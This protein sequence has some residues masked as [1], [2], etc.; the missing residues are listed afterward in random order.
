MNRSPIDHDSSNRIRRTIRKI[1]GK[2]SVG[3]RIVLCA[4]YSMCFYFSVLR[5]STTSLPALFLAGKL[6]IVYQRQELEHGTDSKELHDHRPNNHLLDS[7]FEC[8]NPLHQVPSSDCLE[9]VQSDGKVDTETDGVHSDDVLDP[10]KD[11]NSCIGKEVNVK[12]A[13]NPDREGDQEGGPIGPVHSPSW[14]LPD[15]LTVEFGLN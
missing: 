3:L 4:T 1:P 6:A 7:E 2:S 12:E 14:R 10:S 8:G 15:L 5:R 13:C 9:R 11:G